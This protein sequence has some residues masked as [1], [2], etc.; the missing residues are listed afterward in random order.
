MHKMLAKAS[1]DCTRAAKERSKYSGL[2]KKMHSWFVIAEA[3]R[4]KGT[5]RVLK[6]LSIFFQADSSNVL[7]ALP[8]NAI[9]KEKLL[10][11]KT[12]ADRSK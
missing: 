5:L 9:A 12:I 10:A 1:A 4:I 7:S 11:L 2:S 6:L 3:C 8:H